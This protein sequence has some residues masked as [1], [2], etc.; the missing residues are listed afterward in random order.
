MTS[1]RPPSASLSTLL[2]KLPLRGWA[3]VRALAFAAAAVFAYIGARVLDASSPSISPVLDNHDQALPWLG[4]AL[5]SALLVAWRPRRPSTRPRE[6]AASAIDFVQA[7]RVEIALFL[8]IFAFGVFMRLYRIGSALPP[9]NGLCCEENINGGVAYRTLEGERPLFFLLGRWGSA[10]GFLL[11]DYDAF[12]LRFFFPIMALVTL[13]FLYLLL[14]QLV[15]VPVALF[16]LALYAAAWWPSL[17]AR[18]ATEGTIETVLFSL[19]LVVA[20]RKR[21]AAAALGAGIVAGLIS[22]EYEAFKIVPIVAAGFAGAAAVWEI[23]FRPPLQLDAARERAKA[24]WRIAWR[25]VLVFLMGA[26]I[27]VIPII[28]GEQHGHDVYLT[29]LHRNEGT[30]GE[31]IKD[32]WREQTKLVV[33]VFLPAGPNSYPTSPP[34]DLPDRELLDPV[35]G[36][37]SVAGLIAGVALFM[38]GFRLYFVAWIVVSGFAA[39]LVL[40][41]FA[42]WKLMG[43]LPA[44]VVLVAL[45]VEDV[46]ALVL[47]RFGSGGTRAF[48]G[49]LAIVAAFACWSNADTLFNDI[50]NLHGIQQVYATDAARIYTL[51]NEQRQSGD[52]NYSVAFVNIPQLPGLA[53]PHETYRE[54][55]GA[56]S[57]SAWVCH[58][59]EGVQLAAPEEAWPL[60]GLPEGA[61]V[62]FGFSDP[63]ASIDDIIAQLQ[64]AYPDLGAPSDVIAGPGGYFT[65]AGWRFASAQALAQHGLYGEYF[66]AGASEPAM[67]RI[68]PLNDLAQDTRPDLLGPP[69]TVRW[70]GL[71]YLPEGGQYS[72]EL[73]G[74]ASGATIIL[75]G[76]G[77]IGRPV[78]E[79][80][81]SSSSLRDLAQGW[82]TVEISLFEIGST[83]SL[84]LAWVT[85]DGQPRPMALDDLFPLR[86]LSGWVHER[87]LGLVSDRAMLTTQRIEFSPHESLPI[88]VEAS[89]PPALIEQEVFLTEESWRGVWNVEQPGDYKLRVEFRQGRVSLLID[90]QQIA[91]GDASGPRTSLDVFATLTRG[92]HAIEIVQTFEVRPA[93][94]GVTLSLV[95]AP[96]GS[97]AS[98]S[99]VVPYQGPVA[100]VP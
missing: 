59:L 47:R 53:A 38:R 31:R 81:T 35:L 29:S 100:V 11:F 63:F 4:L 5:L 68:D 25:P 40:A 82:H 26:G 77:F 75:D 99:D 98:L 95:S 57:D 51:C 24:L 42:P 17:R 71:V 85:A 44:F 61:P 45:L 10:L 90:G 41:N 58:D 32:N 78:L 33:E 92:P 96:S 55:L 43:V 70:R 88:I 94:A 18:Q 84:R 1:D 89:A 79:N 66:P 50:A 49:I 67:T 8:L 36:W 60:R 3:A 62:T 73:A 12:G 56:W 54:K 69:F 7:H 64:R 65:Y 39:A 27:V 86:S 91:A 28:I 30:A 23:A 20:V 21:S 72:L 37:L 76:Q 15:S 87:V 22:Y 93:Y 97:N 80:G 16:G 2:A 52:D 14:R 34:R 19:L 83:R 13:V 46:R 6:W 48:A 74:G 9:E